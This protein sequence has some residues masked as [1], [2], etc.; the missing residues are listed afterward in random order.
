M[1]L[2]KLGVGSAVKGGAWGICNY[3]RLPR[4]LASGRGARSICETLR[5]TYYMAFRSRD[6]ELERN[7]LRHAST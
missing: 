2:P 7:S 4:K 5:G 6:T 1:H 3:R